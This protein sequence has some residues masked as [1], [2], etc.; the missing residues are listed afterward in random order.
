M[1]DT[2]TSILSCFGCLVQSAIYMHLKRGKR[3]VVFEPHNGPFLLSD[4]CIRCKKKKN[5]NKITTKKVIKW[6]ALYRYINGVAASPYKVVIFLGK[7]KRFDMS[8]QIIH[9]LKGS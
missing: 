6:V 2:F 3:G 4:V 9:I 7:S 1:K 8:A 5:K